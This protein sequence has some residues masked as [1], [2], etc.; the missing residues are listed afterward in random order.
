MF[1]GPQATS[2]TDGS[3][4]GSDWQKMSSD[5][6]YIETSMNFCWYNSARLLNTEAAW[7]DRS[8]GSDKNVLGK[9]K[10]RVRDFLILIKK[11]ELAQALEF[12]ILH[13][14]WMLFSKNHIESFKRLI[15]PFRLLVESVQESPSLPAT[16]TFRKR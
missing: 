12:R 7:V 1:P 8:I 13:E 11:N 14:S 9:N 15:D 2:R 16:L 4:F 5:G 10:D 6:S 3:V